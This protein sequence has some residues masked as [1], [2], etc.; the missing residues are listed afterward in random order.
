VDEIQPDGE[1]VILPLRLEGVSG[2]PCRV[3]LRR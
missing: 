3:I 2:S 1:L